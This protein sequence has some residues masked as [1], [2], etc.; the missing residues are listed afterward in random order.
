MQNTAITEYSANCMHNKWSTEIHQYS[1]YEDLL[2]NSLMR[3]SYFI[4][5]STTAFFH[6]ET[7]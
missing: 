6:L 7:L 1:V 4:D 2:N 3:S 5:C